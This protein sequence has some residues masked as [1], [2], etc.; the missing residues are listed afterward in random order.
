MSRGGRGAILLQKGEGQSPWPRAPG[1]VAPAAQALNCES[2]KEEHASEVPPG[3]DGRQS[4]HECRSHSLTFSGSHELINRKYYLI[5]LILAS[6]ARGASNRVCGARE[7]KPMPKLLFPPHR[8]ARA[9]ESFTCT[10]CSSS[11]FSPAAGLQPPALIP[12]SSRHLTQELD[13]PTAQPTVHFIP[14][15]P[16]AIKNQKPPPRVPPPPPVL[17]CHAVCEN[18]I[19]PST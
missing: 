15:Q 11:M 9:A 19:T 14:R 1:P 12:Y 5:Y 3:T 6:S 16:F 4:L 8:T 10:R 13:G 7:R 18:S 2:S 17:V